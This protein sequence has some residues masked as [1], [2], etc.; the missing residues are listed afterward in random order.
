MTIKS[1][2]AQGMP[3]HV[4]SVHFVGIGGSGMKRLAKG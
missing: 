3:E 2:F 1:D 4:G